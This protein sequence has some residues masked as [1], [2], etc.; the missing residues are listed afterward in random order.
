ML[1]DSF[2]S[3]AENYKRTLLS[4][5]DGVYMTDRDRRIIFWNPACVKITGYSAAE[6][7]GKRC[8]DNIL[9]H[10]DINGNPLC[11]SSLCP[12]FQS[13][14]KGLPGDSPLVVRA[15]RKGGTRV[16]VEVSV[17][18][19]FGDDGMVMGGVE[20]F[21]D[22]TEKQRLA[23]MKA[24]F[25]SGITHELKNPLTIMQG[26]IELVLSGDTGE[27]NQLQKEFLESAR[28][29]G[30]RF[31]KVLDDLLDFTRFEATEL[32]FSPRRVNLSEVLQRVAGSYN[33]G[34][35]RKGIKITA[36]IPEGI[37]VY[38]DG[39]RL[40]QAF[41]N[42]LSN[43]L[44]YTEK[45]IVEFVAGISGDKA[46]VVVRDSGIGISVEDQGRIFEQFYR[47]DNNM[48]RNISGAGIGLS[49]VKKIIERHGG[50]IYV[51]S[52]PGRGSEFRV[53]L[54]AG[55]EDGKAEI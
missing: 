15:R 23:E 18:P 7:L 45:G 28:E 42:L 48:T 8:S 3:Q 13:M 14:E 31:K 6:V 53:F 39:N 20:I 22:I 51:E 29:E 55:E 36:D 5:N 10:V 1:E 47:V 9:S 35:A 38:G 24:R 34:A 40:Y 32:S 25:L 30:D 44:K 16:T 21:R 46:T 49:I 12:L 27:I 41:S 37:F 54:P 26:F 2:L 33:A 43:A 11:D 50:E 17:A 19:L 4:V 52:I